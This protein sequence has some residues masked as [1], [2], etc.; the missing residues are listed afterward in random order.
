VGPWQIYCTVGSEAKVQYLMDN[1]GIERSRIFHSRD[2]SFQ[3]DI[4]RATDNRG[5][6]LVLNSLSGDLLHASWMC[7]AEFGTM[8][9]IGKRDFLRRAKLT[10]EP[11]EQ[12]RTFIG[13]ELRLLWQL[14]QKKAA[15]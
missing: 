15:E 9:E 12:N 7:V 13:L 10:M 6:D 8:V 3:P 5:V 1:Y 11:F 2:S 14:Q 4:M